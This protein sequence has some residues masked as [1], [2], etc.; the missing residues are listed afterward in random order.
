MF[1]VNKLHAFL[2]WSPYIEIL[3]MAI[4][5][6][7]LQLLL[8]KNCRLSFYIIIANCA[9]SMNSMKNNLYKPKVE[10]I[11]FILDA[12]SSQN[13]VAVQMFFFFS[14]NFKL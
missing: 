7:V 12:H 11:A 2:S 10:I 9:F 13:F 5:L 6:T 1:Y 8:I 14:A 4:D 3:H